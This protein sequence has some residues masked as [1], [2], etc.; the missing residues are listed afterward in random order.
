M[1]NSI[2]FNNVS[3]NKLTLNSIK[4]G[5]H[6]SASNI[7]I[8]KVKD[9]TYEKIETFTISTEDWQELAENEY[10]AISIIQD[11]TSKELI[12]NYVSSGV[13]TQYASKLSGSNIYKYAVILTATHTI[14][15]T[16]IVEL[17]NTDPVL[18]SKYGFQMASQEGQNI[19]LVSTDK[20]SESVSISIKVGV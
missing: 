5:I 20:P 10:I 7:Q 16:T 9:D 2:K 4:E 15:D 6:L 11:E 1:T 14:K 17:L 12:K 18:F 8:I 19:L 13:Y 3:T